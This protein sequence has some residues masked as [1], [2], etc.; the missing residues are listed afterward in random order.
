MSPAKSQLKPVSKASKEPSGN[1]A[2]LERFKRLGAVQIFGRVS[3]IERLT[4]TKHLATMMKAGVPLN[5]ALEIL[6]ERTKSGTFKRILAAVLADVE[7]GS[8]LAAALEKHDGVFDSVYISMVEISEE[9]GS[10]EENLTFMAEQLA[11]EYSFRKKVQTASLYPTLILV[12]AA[13]MGGFLSFFVLPKL[14][15]FFSAL[16][17]ELPLSTKIL[18][19]IATAMKD[20]GVAI[21]SSI[22]AGYIVFRTA[23]AHRWFRPHWDALLLRMPVIGPIVQDIQLSSLSRNLGVLLASGVPLAEAINVLAKQTRHVSYQRR[24][25]FLSA[26]LEQG[27]ALGD[28]LKH[29]RFVEFPLLVVKMIEVGEK[30]GKLDEALLYLGDFYEEELDAVS[31]NLTT[32]LEPLLLLVIGITVGLVALAIISP[33]YQL[34]GSIRR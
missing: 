3:L 15:D 22:I 17:I 8:S 11:K 27:K 34:T 6:Q 20:H 26:K 19:F 1:S 14:V 2:W 25:Q 30:T 28:T 7:N 29:E 5:E 21:I 32:V 18:L 12:S 33:I 23:I 4:F 9:S 13:V 31:R 16:D 24:L 10:L